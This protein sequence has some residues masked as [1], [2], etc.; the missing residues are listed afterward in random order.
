VTAQRDASA[1]AG[2]ARSASAGT[3][4]PKLYG[5]LSLFPAPGAGEPPVL[6]AAERRGV[7]VCHRVDRKGNPIAPEW[8]YWRDLSEARQARDALT[9]CGPRCGGIHTCVEVA[10]PPRR[11]QA[12]A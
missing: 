11:S 4:P 6:R 8:S 1:S 7:L 10:V 9:P 5:P 12:P 2:P 3:D